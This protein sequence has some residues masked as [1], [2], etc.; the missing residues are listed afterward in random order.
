MA[1]P[2]P[3][4][5]KATITN[6]QKASLGVIRNAA[7]GTVICPNCRARLASN[8]TAA[9]L[10]V[11]PLVLYVAWST[12]T[13]P[14]LLES[15]VVLSFVAAVMLSVQIWLVPL[16]KVAPPSFTEGADENSPTRGTK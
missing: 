2:C 14:S 16:I 3:H 9:W 5:G 1:H 12:S 4:C 7:V 13:D 15:L 6:R 10:A 11:A 8:R